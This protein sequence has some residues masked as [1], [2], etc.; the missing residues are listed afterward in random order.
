MLKIAKTS[1]NRV[2]IELDGGINSDQMRTA[3]DQLIE[4]SDG[5]KNGLMLYRI[6][7][8]E[9][10][11]AGAIAVEFSRLPKLFGLLG[12]F[13]RCAVLSDSA[14][15]RTTAEIEGAVFPGI[16]IKSFELNES[17]AAEKWLSD[18]S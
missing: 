3:L 4:A 6:T 9:M 14:W 18:Q 16:K 1:P 5:V 15:I 7:D 12:K 17:E 11:T 13:D 2:D 10:P 8:F